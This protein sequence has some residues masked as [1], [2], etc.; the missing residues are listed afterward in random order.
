MIE[1]EEGERQTVEPGMID[2]L[3]SGRLSA[4]TKSSAA[5][6]SSDAMTWD[7]PRLVVRQS[8]CIGKAC[9]ACGDSFSLE[10]H[11]NTVACDIE[12][13]VP[14]ILTPSDVIECAVAQVKN[15]LAGCPS[16]F[17]DFVPKDDI[18]A[19]RLSRG[20]APVDDA[21]VHVSGRVSEFVTRFPPDKCATHALT[22]E[23]V[24][25]GRVI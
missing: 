20:V 5:A 1:I 18:N 2:P 23:R 4:R 12:S 8:R 17:R 7:G 6:S 25:V 13:F 11:P 14:D 22:G 15:R 21:P 16:D 3:V 19:L 10:P 9:G 24:L